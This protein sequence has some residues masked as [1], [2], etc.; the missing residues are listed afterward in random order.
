MLFARELTQEYSNFYLQETILN[1]TDLEQLKD[2]EIILIPGIA[3]ET[4]DSTDDRSVLDLSFYFEN[5]L[6]AQERHFEKL[7]LHVTRMRSSSY[8]ITEA[9]F[10]IHEKMV[11]LKK[12]GRK[13]I[14]MT[15]SMGGLILL[16]YLI[17]M[18]PEATSNV[19][20]IVFMQSPFHGSPIAS[21]YFQNP[22]LARSVLGPIMRFVHTSEDSINSLTI[23]SRKKWMNKY[24]QSINGLIKKI[25]IITVSGLSLNYPSLMLP[26]INIIAYGCITVWKDKCLSSKLFAGPYDNSDGMVPF[27]SS[28]LENADHV[29]LP[30]V[31]HGETVL[32]MPFRNIDR[33]KMSSAL[34]KLILLKNL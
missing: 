4:F 22:Y 24:S 23:E 21:V 10:E 16:E 1:K 25:P 28:R 19:H 14:F 26:S 34:L 12:S 33:V 31:D 27:E 30:G 32:A 9:L 7:G 8:S 15:H 11:E 20:G 18:H 13:A 2:L 17:K 6:A 29:K 3:S 5:Y